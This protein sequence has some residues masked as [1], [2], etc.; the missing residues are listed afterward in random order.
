EGAKSRLIGFDPTQ[1]GP[2]LSP[3]TN[4]LGP[5]C[6]GDA[7]APA[8]LSQSIFWNWEECIQGDGTPASFCEISLLGAY[9]APDRPRQFDLFRD[10]ILINKERAAFL[11]KDALPLSCGTV[12]EGTC[13]TVFSIEKGCPCPEALLPSDSGEQSHCWTGTLVLSQY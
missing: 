7:R 6:L 3:I 1:C 12:K 2:M 11:L 5:G 8:G 9:T 10:G 4:T 13:P